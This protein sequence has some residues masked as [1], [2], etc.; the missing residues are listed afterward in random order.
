MASG[1]TVVYVTGMPV[2]WK[3]HFSRV[4][5]AIPYIVICAFWVT[6]Y[7]QNMHV[8]FLSTLHMV[9]S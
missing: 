6:F 8:V 1:V 2:V 7:A 9:T 5:Q 3:L 4:V